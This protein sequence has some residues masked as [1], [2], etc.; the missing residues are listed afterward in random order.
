MTAFI[1]AGC[2]KNNL[3]QTHKKQKT[4]SHMIMTQAEKR[5]VNYDAREN[6]KVIEQNLKNKDKNQK[7][8]EKQ[9]R[10]QNEE[11]NKLNQHSSKVKK[12]KTT[13]FTF[14]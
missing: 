5:D 13:A 10:K 8:A 7:I 11:L 6:Q 4:P 12:V 3:P 1:I 2:S 9:R 14:Y